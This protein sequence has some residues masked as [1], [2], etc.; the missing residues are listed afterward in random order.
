MTSDTMKADSAQ[1]IDETSSQLFDN[2]FDRDRARAFI[3]E[4]VQSDFKPRWRAR[5]MGG[6]RRMPVT[7]RAPGTGVGANADTLGHVRENRDH[8]AAGQAQHR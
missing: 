2:R 3:E 5:A 6:W 4:L 7:L 8:R 1:P